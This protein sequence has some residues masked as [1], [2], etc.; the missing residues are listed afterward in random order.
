MRSSS[1]AASTPII[2]HAVG[3]PK[4]TGPQMRASAPAAPC[5]RK[6]AASAPSDP[7]SAVCV[8][9]TTITVGGH[10]VSRNSGISV[11]RSHLGPTRSL[12]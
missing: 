9:Q 5:S 12:S 6:N 11:C 8:Y 7:P 1:T 3:V 4:K 2:A 10:T